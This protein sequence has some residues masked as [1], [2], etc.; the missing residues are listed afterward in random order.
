LENKIKVQTIYANYLSN[1][2]G[3]SQTLKRL[4]R[5]SFEFEKKNIDFDVISL[6]KDTNNTYSVNQDAPNRNNTFFNL[7][8]YTSHHSVIKYLE[9]KTFLFAFISIYFKYIRYSCI[10]RKRWLKQSTKNPDIFV[11]HEPITFIVF[12]KIIKKEDC[13]VVLFHHGDDLLENMFYDYYPVLKK[14]SWIKKSINKFTLNSLLALDAVVFINPISYDNAKIKYVSLIDK[15]R[16]V[17]NGI[18]DLNP[19]DTVKRNFRDGYNVVTAGT[20]NE[21]KNQL[22]ILQA[23]KEAIPK[24]NYKVK[25]IIVGDG[26]LLKTLIDY[27][28]ANNLNQ[29]VEFA[30]NQ[31]NVS[32]FL[33]KANI[34]MLSS[35]KEG[36]PLAVVEAL[37]FSLPIISSN[38]S[39][40]G[41]CVI[42]GK[43][44]I[45]YQSKDKKE[46]S[47]LFCSLDKYHWEQFGDNSRKLFK[48]KF[49]F[50]QMQDSYINLISELYCNN[51][52][53]SKQ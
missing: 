28:D 11:F 4:I 39:G 44:G 45:L 33:L 13:K 50:S 19:D 9:K 7:L 43:N 51:T 29:Y 25:V 49:Q 36:L 6:D 31:K 14:I 23:L 15:F 26:P 42:E 22:L 46:L 40:I 35:K 5:D 37:S 27:S 17:Q 48:S 10:I 18:D 41:A 21:R 3:P 2:I 30:G 52:I 53:F 16:L 47:N 1:S 34:F 8:K 32:P 24:L 20:V 38:I 12:R